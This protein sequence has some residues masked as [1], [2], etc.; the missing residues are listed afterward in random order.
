MLEQVIKEMRA[1]SRKDIGLEVETENTNAIGL[2]RSCGFV[3]ITTYGYY[4]IDLY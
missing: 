3:E 2:Y 1:V 4:N